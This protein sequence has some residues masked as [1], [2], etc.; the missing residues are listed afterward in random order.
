ME[1]SEVNGFHFPEMVY[2]RDEDLNDE[3]SEK[4]EFLSPNDL[5][6]LSKEKVKG[7][8]KKNFFCRFF[9]LCLP[10]P[11]NIIQKFREP[12]RKMQ[13]SL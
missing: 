2:L 5:L 3:D 13:G 9:S 4:G 8:G 7:K 1:C 12:K 10:P 11:S 6:L